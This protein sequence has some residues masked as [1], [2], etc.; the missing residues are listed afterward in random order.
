MP[1][2]NTCSGQEKV[3]FGYEVLCCSIDQSE[4]H[5]CFRV[6]FQVDGPAVGIG[7]SALYQIVFV[8]IYRNLDQCRTC[9]ELLAGGDSVLAMCISL[10]KVLYPKECSIPCAG[11]CWNCSVDTVNFSI[12]IQLHTGNMPIIHEG[13]IPHHGGHV[14]G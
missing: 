14:I 3:V 4:D 13:K 5:A 6:C 12:Y 8:I 10:N 9:F 2:K 1:D 7:V 11:I